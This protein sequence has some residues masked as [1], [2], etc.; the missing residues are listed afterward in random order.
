MDKK[1]TH[2]LQE[3]A[4]SLKKAWGLPLGSYCEVLEGGG[5]LVSG[6]A[7]HQLAMGVGSKHAQSVKVAGRFLRSFP[8]SHVGW[9][10]WVIF[11]MKA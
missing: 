9:F 3:I 11:S 10:G 6:E 7:E 5:Y 2:T 8:S 4:L 1:F